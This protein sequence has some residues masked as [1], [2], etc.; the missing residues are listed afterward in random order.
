MRG[1]L[2]GFL[3]RA[4]CLVSTAFRAA[5]DLAAGLLLR[6]LARACRDRAAG[7]AARVGS[8]CSAFLLPRALRAE[9]TWSGS[10]RPRA[11]SR[12]ADFRVRS[13][14]PARFGAGKSTPARRAFDSPM[15]IACFVERA[16]CLPSRTW[17]ISSRTNSP[18]CVLGA[19]P[20]ALSW[21]ARFLV[22][23]SGIGVSVTRSHHSF[24]RA[25]CCAV[26]IIVSVST[27]CSGETS[28]PGRTGDL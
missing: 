26:V 20:C 21:R 13:E 16:P 14:V 1:F 6:A 11:E 5:A 8:A 4:A 12:C 2:A 18:A 10:T 22:S 19:F 15:A 9:G 25:G 28:N 17:S 3:R 23:A 27:T 7:V 24:A